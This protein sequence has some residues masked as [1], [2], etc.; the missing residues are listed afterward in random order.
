MSGLGK[1][2]SKLGNWL[3]DK[4]LKQKWLMTETNLNK[5]TISKLCSDNSPPK[6]E[7]MKVVLNSLRKIDSNLQ[8]ND[9]WEI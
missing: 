4:G 8:V 1:P 9:F 2:R 6:V 3:D 7:T 5:N